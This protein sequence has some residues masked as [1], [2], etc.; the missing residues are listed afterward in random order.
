MR[1]EDTQFDLR[2]A[3]LQVLKVVPFGRSGTFVGLL[4]EVF[5]QPLQLCIFTVTDLY[6]SFQSN[7][8]SFL[9]SHSFEK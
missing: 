2:E 1:G 3:D 4:M 8:R 9:T 6:I 7:T 5:V